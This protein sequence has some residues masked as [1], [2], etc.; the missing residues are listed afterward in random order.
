MFGAKPSRRLSSQ[1]EP[2]EQNAVNE[3][4]EQ[5]GTWA[6]LGRKGVVH[7]TIHRSEGLVPLFPCSPCVH[8]NMLLW[9]CS[10]FEY[11]D[12]SIAEICSGIHTLSIIGISAAFYGSHMYCKRARIRLKSVSSVKQAILAMQEKLQI[13]GFARNNSSRI[14]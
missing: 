8:M 2:S 6:R 1:V 12:N 5:G 13:L 4:C 9:H 14:L 7:S 10:I 3:T 11:L